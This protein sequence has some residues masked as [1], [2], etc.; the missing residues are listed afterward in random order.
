MEAVAMETLETQ[1]LIIRPFVMGDLYEAHQ[2]LDVDIEW[3]GRSFTLDQRRERLQFYVGLAQWED[4]GRL[5]GFRAITLKASLELI[6]IC[7]FH[8]DV[9]SPGWKAI[10]W[11]TLFR[12]C[13]SNTLGGHASLELSIGYALCHPARGHGYATEAVKALLDHAFRTWQIN[14]V[15]AITDQ[16]NADSVKV[17]QRVGMRTAQNPDGQIAYP[18]VVGL[19]E[20]QGNFRLSNL[21]ESN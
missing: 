11:P 10:F 1:R 7:G 19:I 14:R 4:T 21:D 20:N 2:V 18:G 12:D 9:W 6:G 15:F 17:M 8:P 5:Y 3:S 16:S 13:D